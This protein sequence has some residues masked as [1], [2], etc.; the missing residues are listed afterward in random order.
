MAEGLAD[1]MRARGYR[2]C[3]YFGYTESL[4][5]SGSIEKNTGHK[6]AITTTSTPDNYATSLRNPAYFEEVVKKTLQW[7]VHTGATRNRRFDEYDMVLEEMKIRD[8]LAEERNKASAK[9]Y[10]SNEVRASAVR[11]QF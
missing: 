2:S 10:G 8:R 9:W 5:Y 11:E 1:A 6:Y 7:N 4:R 3:E